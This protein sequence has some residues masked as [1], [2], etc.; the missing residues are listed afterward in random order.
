MLT[1]H[2]DIDPA[3]GYRLEPGIL[4]LGRTLETIRLPLPDDYAATAPGKPCLGARV[5]GKSSRARFGILIHFTAPT[6][7][8]GFEGPITLEIM[9]LGKQPFVLYP[10]MPICQLVIEEVQGLP[11]PNES[12][13]QGQATPAGT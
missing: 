10:D 9:N 7:H 13:F 6:I 5:E 1:D 3:Q 4:V 12:Q 2:V 11:T 8:A